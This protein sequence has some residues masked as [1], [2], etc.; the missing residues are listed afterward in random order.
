MDRSEWRMLPAATA[1]AMMEVFRREA[2]A[3]HSLR[4]W[5]LFYVLSKGGSRMEFELAHKAFVEAHAKMRQGE[6]LRRLL[7]GHNHAE[8]LFLKNVWW[9]VIGHFD[10]L[11]PEYEVHDFKDGV[12][13]LDFAYLRPPYRICLEADSIGTHLRDIS[14][15]QYADHLQRQNDLINDDWKVYRFSYD[16]IKDRPRRCQLTLQ[17]IMGKWYGSGT[18][19]I[20]LSPVEKE[21]LRLV[22]E[23]N[24]PLTPSDAMARLS[25]CDRSA[26][27]LLHGLVEKKILLPAGGGSMR[28]RAYKLDPACRGLLL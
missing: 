8:I 25:I 5:R 6:S 4:S 22:K 12:R 2:H 15:W 11:F 27:T 19:P 14:R 13:F 10:Y 24:A 18:P 3:A 28:I 7:E 26:R 21:L 23:R 16:E 20:P 9:P 1:S 17:Q